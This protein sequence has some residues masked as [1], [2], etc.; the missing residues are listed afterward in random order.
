LIDEDLMDDERLFEVYL[1]IERNILINM[2]LFDL[3]MKLIV[4]LMQL[5]TIVFDDHI[6]DKNEYS[7][8]DYIVQYE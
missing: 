7:I 3:S 6:I 1:T 8:M 2:N 5:M 4:D